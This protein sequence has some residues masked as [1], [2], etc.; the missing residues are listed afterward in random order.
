M[1]SKLV[2]L[3]SRNIWGIQTVAW[4]TGRMFSRRRGPAP[5]QAMNE[6]RWS[7]RARL[8]CVALGERGSEYPPDNVYR[9]NRIMYIY[10]LMQQIR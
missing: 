8:V 10:I 4:S 3:Y 2:Q 1:F 6:R 7:A 5:H 9:V